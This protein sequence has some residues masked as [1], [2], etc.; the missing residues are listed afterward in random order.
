[1]YE[2]RITIAEVIENEWFKKGYK[3]PNF[4]QG[5]VSLA[6]VDAIFNET[7]VRLMFY[8]LLSWSLPFLWLYVL[9]CNLVLSVYH[10]D[11]IPE[12]LLWRGGK[13]GLL[14]LSL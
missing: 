12:S 8:L 11:R 7:A 4:E 10:L 3:P 2:Q 1:M 14:H 6:D 13:T 9:V 5:D